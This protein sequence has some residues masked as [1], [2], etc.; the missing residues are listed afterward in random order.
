[1]LSPGRAAGRIFGDDCTTSSDRRHQLAMLSRVADV[2]SATHE[3]DRVAAAPDAGDVC[4]TVDPLGHAADHGDTI[5][6]QKSCCIQRC[7]LCMLRTPAGADD[8]D[9]AEVFRD[10]TF[11]KKKNRSDLG[12]FGNFQVAGVVESQYADLIFPTVL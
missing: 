6:S 10:I 7:F 1:M 2:E 8:R 3:S 9:A 4:I 5:L 12:A 11:K